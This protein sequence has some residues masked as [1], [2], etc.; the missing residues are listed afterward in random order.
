MEQRIHRIHDLQ[1]GE[2]VFDYGVQ[3][4]GHIVGIRK[5]GE[6]TVYDLEMD[7][8]EERENLTMFDCEIPEDELKWDTACPTDLYQIAPGLVARDGNPVCYEHQE[9]RDEYPYFSPYLDE[10]LFGIE[11]GKPE[12]WASR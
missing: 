10:N 9:T 5:E 6:F 4:W 12:E 2:R 8:W 11:V 7:E 3:T 1:I